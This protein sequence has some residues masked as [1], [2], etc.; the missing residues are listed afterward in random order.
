MRKY[1]IIAD[2]NRLFYVG[3]GDKQSV[4][5]VFV[6]FRQVLQRQ[7]VLEIDRQYLEVVGLSLTGY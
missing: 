5:W 7:Y 3:L 2:E 1:R 6:M 4:K